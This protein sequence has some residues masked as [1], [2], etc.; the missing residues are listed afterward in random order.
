M[1]A[2][3]HW[4]YSLRN[5][6][7]LVLRD[8]NYIGTLVF[9]AILGISIKYLFPDVMR[10][11]ISLMEVEEYSYIS[12]ALVVSVILLAVGVSEVTYTSKLKMGNLFTSGVFVLT[13]MLLYVLSKILLFYSLILGTISMIMF[14]WGLFI[15]FYDKSELKK[16]LL[17]LIAL[18]MLIPL[19]R[20]II[21]SL[22]VHLTRSVAILASILSNA[23]II[24]RP[25]GRVYLTAMGIEGEVRF[26]IITACSGI[27]SI[28]SFIALLPLFIYITRNTNPKRRLIAITISTITGLFIVFIGNVLRVAMLVIMAKNYGVETAYDLFHATP[29]YIYT[30]IAVIVSIFLLFKLINSR[31]TRVNK[32]SVR[33]NTE[34]VRPGNNTSPILILIFISLVIISAS[35]VLQQHISYHKASIDIQQYSYDYILSHPLNIILNDKVKIVYEKNVP[36]LERALGSSLVKAIGIRYNKSYFSGY[37]EFAET[38]GRFHGWWVCLTYQGY[39]V[40]RVWTEEMNS[41][42]IT[43]IEYSKNNKTFLLGYVIFEVPVYFGGQ[44]VGEGYIRL[45]LFIPVKKDITSASEDFKDTL[46]NILRGDILQAT[47]KRQEIL[48]VLSTIDMVLIV[49]T[50][51]Y[52][53]LAFFWHSIYIIFRKLKKIG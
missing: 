49:V 38:P 3:Y 33:N 44:T 46:R 26:E 28:S 1:V 18:L 14:I 40:K 43:F 12:T 27:I 15:L 51:G 32:N 37:V 5:N 45:S 17:P 21:D 6:G 4:C 23:E 34:Q 25:D 20:E 48:D 42:M 11:L 29:S 24:S 31:H 36:A 53:M 41:S 39:N 8:N 19:P 10:Q 16:L 52:Y 7:L 47:R 2:Y 50:T 13:S 30:A 22:S 9:I 35:L